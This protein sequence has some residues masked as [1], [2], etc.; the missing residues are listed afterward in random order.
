VILDTIKIALAAFVLCVF[1]LS[2]M[3]Q[4]TPGMAAPDLVIVLVIAVAMFRGP[5]AA[6]ITGFA[7]GLLLDAMQAER[8]G[9]SSLLYMAAGLWVAKRLEPKDEVIPTRSGVPQAPAQFFYVMAGAVVVQLG[10]AFGHAL[11]GDSYPVRYLFSNTVI[12]TL[13]ATAVAALL[14]L[15][16]MRRLLPP[17]I[18]RFDV[19]AIPAA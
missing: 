17:S 19:P 8:L 2:G 18:P 12:P 5:E 7:V 3:P 14:L 9:L 11:L 10:L 16:L 15:P 13:V 1:Q 6:V 4:L